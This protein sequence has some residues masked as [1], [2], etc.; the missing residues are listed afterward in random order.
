MS[1]PSNRRLTAQFSDN[2]KFFLPLKFLSNW[3][4]K[5]NDGKAVFAD[6]IGDI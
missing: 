5:M 2:E 6:V 3:A 1:I 4:N